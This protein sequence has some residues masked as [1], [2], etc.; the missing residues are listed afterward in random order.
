MLAGSELVHIDEEELLEELEALKQP[1]T[2]KEVDGVIEV[3]GEKIELPS[4]P[5][6]PVIIKGEAKAEEVENERVLIAE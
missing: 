4:V 2:I 5:K 6:E 1:E 3:D